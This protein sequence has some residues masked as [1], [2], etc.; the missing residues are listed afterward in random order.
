MELAMSPRGGHETNTPSI[1][2]QLARVPEVDLLVG[3]GAQRHA[4]VLR[5]VDRPARRWLPV[6]LALMAAAVLLLV[7]FGPH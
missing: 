6:T 4:H 5:L 7:A 3:L 1:A 2:I